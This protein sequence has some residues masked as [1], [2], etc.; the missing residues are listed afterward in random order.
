MTTDPVFAILFPVMTNNLLKFG[1]ENAK[2][3][4][5]WHFS[6]PSGWTCP[7]ATVCMTR[8]DKTTGKISDGKNQEFRCYAAMDEAR[9]PTVR[10]ARWHNFD[11]LKNL[12]KDEM[13]ELISDSLPAGLRRGGLLRVH[14]GGD[15]FKADYFQAW[16][17][18]AEKFKKITFYAYTKSLHIWEK[19]INVIPDNFI[20]TASK[21]GRFDEKIEL[22]GLKSA[23]VFLSEEEATMANLEIDHDDSHAWEGKDSFALLIHGQQKAG[24]KASE[25]QKALR[26]K[27]IHGIKQHK[28]KEVTVAA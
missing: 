11:L 12:T 27:G 7:A 21:G 9:Y 22:L 10:K 5:I 28:K 25:A 1:F 18:V 26:K 16:K 8:A 19:F 14:I 2:L 3:K 24:S 6:L 4:G 13:V 17:E 23:E 20:L 15:F